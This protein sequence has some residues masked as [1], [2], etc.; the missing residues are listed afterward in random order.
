M[1]L[2]CNSIT[3]RDPE[4]SSVSRTVGAAA[5]MRL[6]AHGWREDDGNTEM[7]SKNTE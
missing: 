3:N 7:M 1:Y 6:S 5:L 2:N 4:M